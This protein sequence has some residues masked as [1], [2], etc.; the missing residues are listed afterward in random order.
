M[1]QEEKDDPVLL[2]HGSGGRLTRDL[3]ARLFLPAFK[4]RFL[5]TLDDAAV[6][7]VEE[8]RLAFTTDA[9][10]VDPI[11][12]EGGDIGRLAVC[13]TVNDLATAGARPLGLAVAYILEEGFPLKDLERVTASVKEAAAE[14]GVPIVTGDTK[15][16]ASGAADKM[17][18]TTSGIGWIPPEIDLSGNRARAGD[19]VLISGTVGD[20]GIAIVSARA[21]LGLSSPLKSD[22]APL[23][24]LVSALLEAD[25]EVRALRDPT[26][27]GIAAAVNELAEQSGVGIRLWE[28][29]IPIRKE[30]QGACA[31]LGFDPL[32]LANEGKMIA[33]VGAEGADAALAA[34]QSTPW[35]KDAAIIG[36]V[37]PPS[38][39]PAPVV[40]ETAVGGTRI[41]DMP[42]GDQLPRIC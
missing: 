3:M 32:T 9:Y 12:F 35:G 24:H 17:F 23:N 42:T 31:L 28:G 16:V 40:L 18:L 8:G 36:E 33:V 34:M 25:A 13:G 38:S 6:I 1:A 39:Q 20:H 19:R 2:A 11:F 21:E 26:R 22:C 5:E 4:N 29:G 15:V 41:L 14:A 7:E 10:V 37:V 27:G 30:V